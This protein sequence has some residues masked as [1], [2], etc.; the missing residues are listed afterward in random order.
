[1]NLMLRILKYFYAEVLLELKLFLIGYTWNTQGKV[2]LVWSH[3]VTF[4]YA[5]MTI[6]IFYLNNTISTL[7][8]NV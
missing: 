1:M 7:A 5:F 3:I 4:V 8:F 6:H 2:V